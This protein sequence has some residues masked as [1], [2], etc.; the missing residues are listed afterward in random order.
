MYLRLIR[1]FIMYLDEIYKFA[2]FSNPEAKAPDL[3]TGGPARN[4]A[5]F[6]PKAWKCAVEW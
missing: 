3:I 2:R 1:N 6:F 4:S 5:A